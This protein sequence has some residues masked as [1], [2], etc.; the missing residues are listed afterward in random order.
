MQAIIDQSPIT[1]APRIKAPTLILSNTGDY[2]VTIT[3]SY[4]LYH[5]LKD[6][7]VSVQ[8]IAYP[9]GGHFPP[10][11]VHQRDVRRRW[12]EWIARHFAAS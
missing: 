5:A 11:P 2:R 12:I 6:N 9:V 4:K 1:A 8:F 7:G 3:Q 10:D